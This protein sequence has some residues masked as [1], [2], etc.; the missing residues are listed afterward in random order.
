MLPCPTETTFRRNIVRAFTDKWSR[1]RALRDLTGLTGGAPTR[2][3]YRGEHQH[4]N[5]L[6]HQLSQTR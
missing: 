6:E 3:S 2:C 4:S 5:V 1:L